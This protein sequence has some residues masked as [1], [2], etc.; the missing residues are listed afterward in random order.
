MIYFIKSE[1]GHVKIGY[2]ENDVETRVNQLQAGCPFNLSILKTITGDRIQEKL[3]HKKFKKDR[4]LREWFT[5]TTEL[6]DY[7]E[8]PYPLK[9][10]EKIKKEK[11]GHKDEFTE[12]RQLKWQEKKQLAGFCI[13]CGKKPIAKKSRSR[14]EI[15][16]ATKRM[17][18]LLRKQQVRSI[19]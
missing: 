1:S 19:K 13:V 11:P 18:T 6:L 8:R 2:S 4:T 5:I 7:I 16:L 12:S 9:L 3:I 15:C 14:C 17:N 10:P